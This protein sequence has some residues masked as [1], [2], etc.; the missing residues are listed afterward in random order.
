MSGAERAMLQALGPA[1]V[2]LQMA[3]SP[4]E[5]LDKLRAAGFAVVPVVATEGILRAGN[6]A[7]KNLEGLRS[8][9]GMLS[10]WAA[11]LAAAQEDGR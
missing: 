6:R 9:H 11:M 2:A 5:V 7:V 10:V 1:A 8:L 3:P 4:R